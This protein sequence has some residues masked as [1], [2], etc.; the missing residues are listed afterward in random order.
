M[1]QLTAILC[2]L[3]LTAC[4]G[5]SSPTSPGG[6]S[7]RAALTISAMTVEAT[8]AGSGYR[9]LVKMTVQNTGQASGTMTALTFR[10]TAAGGSATA[11]P[12]IT[13]AFGNTT[14][15]AGASAQ[16]G[17]MTITDESGSAGQ[18]TSVQATIN[19]NDSTGGNTATRTENLAAL[20]SSFA[21]SGTVSETIP[22]AS[23]RIAGARVE[24]MDG[25]HAGKSAM[26]A[27]DGTFRIEG[28]TGNLNVRITAPNYED[29]SVGFDMSQDR[30]ATINIKPVFAPVNQELTGTI[31]GGDT[32]CSDGTFT[33][34][35]K[36]IN[37]GLHHNGNIVVDM[38]W[39]PGTTD[40]DLTLWRGGTLI[41]SSKG[42]TNRESVSSSGSAG[43]SYQ[44]RI[45]YYEGGSIT[46]YRIRISRPN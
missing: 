37:F 40:L 22:T 38:D 28:L 23:T 3:T 33:K 26:T 41:A 2:L 31:S 45:T 4:G 42:V 7:P 15:A 5:S 20:P 34:P 44:L 43:S 6:N 8:R 10:L 14:L 36:T 32:T 30:T 24:V 11:T 21:L 16:S 27:G 13:Q 19:Y 39:S 17:E 29:H 18:A 25:P 1:R 9:Y 12:A 46:N 35:C